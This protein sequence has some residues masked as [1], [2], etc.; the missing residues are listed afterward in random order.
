MLRLHCLKHVPFEGLG[1]IADWSAARGYETNVAELSLDDPLPPLENVDMLFVM[2][3]PMGVHDVG[4]H[5]WLADEKRYV[6]AA[7]DAGVATIG[8]CLGAQLLAE[9]LGATVTPNAHSEIGWW[10][11]E[12]TGD[13]TTS[14]AFVT[15]PGRFTTFHWHSD[16][17]SLPPGCALVATSAACPTQAFEFERGR[18]TGLQFHPE[19]D[20]VRI[21]EI[22]ARCAID[23]E[24]PGRWIQQ[25]AAFLSRYDLADA[26]R[27]DLWRYLDAFV[28][29]HVAIAEPS[30]T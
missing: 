17:F 11:V 13:P 30:P 7:I 21:E 4:Q 6:R 5:P 18:V 8:I 15:L 23:V 2:G 24:H 26:I 28:A 3:G 10:E 14:T 27:D 12:L 9:A 20:I 29:Q 1:T 22:L 19:L 25:P 16:T